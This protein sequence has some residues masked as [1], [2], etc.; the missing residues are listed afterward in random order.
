LEASATIADLIMVCSAAAASYAL[1]RQE[2][3]IAAAQ[4]IEKP[5][6]NLDVLRAVQ[7]VWGWRADSLQSCSENP[8]TVSVSRDRKTV[9]MRY[10]KPLEETP[11]P[12]TNLE[13][14]VVDSLPLIPTCRPESGALISA[15]RAFQSRS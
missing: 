15:T 13:F 14:D 5:R 4:P 6:V 3:V 1:H 2:T 11:N 8:Q 9:S 12:I 7:G 10:A